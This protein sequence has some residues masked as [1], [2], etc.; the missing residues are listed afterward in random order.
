[1]RL[2]NIAAALLLGSTM[3]ASG[4]YAQTAPGEAPGAT[5]GMNTTG[6]APAPGTDTTANPTGQ[7][8]QLADT[9]DRPEKP[10]GV[11]P[12]ETASTGFTDEDS[13]A[14]DR[15]G[16]FARDLFTDDTRTS[17]RPGTEINALYQELNEE[18]QSQL[19]DFCVQVKGNPTGH[20][21]SVLSMCDSINAI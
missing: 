2:T 13:S 18:D 12:S 20:S 16:E 6:E 17:L 5:G 7:P 1:M 11:D 15:L 19:R 10:Q 21:A 9:E 4:A 14:F 3:L 8:G